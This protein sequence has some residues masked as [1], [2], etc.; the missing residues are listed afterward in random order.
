MIIRSTE[1]HGIIKLRSQ[2]ALSEAVEEVM[3]VIQLLISI[4]ISIKLA[5][6]VR[7]YNMGAKFMAINI[8]TTPHTNDMKIWYEYV[9]EY[10]EDEI[11]K[12][13]LKSSE[14]DMILSQY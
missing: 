3:L 5:V 8:T 2:V 4:K 10:V 9:D 7:V 13:I 14:N 11:V 1:K 6:M 12:I